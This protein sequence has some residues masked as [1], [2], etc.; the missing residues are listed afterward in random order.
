MKTDF[1]EFV[2]EILHK[3][4][5]A[6]YQIYIVGGVVRDLMLKRGTGDWD[7]TTDATPEQILELFPDGF[8]NNQ[9][10]T[11]GIAHESSEKPYEITTYRTEHGYADKRRPDKVSW[12]KS[13]EEDLARRDFT[14]NAMAIS[15]SKEIV[16]P[17]GGQK[18]LEKK[19][20][21]TVGNPV[22]RFSEDSLRMMRAVRIAAEL[23]FLI[24]EKTFDAIKMHAQDLKHVSWERIRDELFKILASGYPDEGTKMLHSSGLLTYILPELE[25]AIGV[26]QKS[27]GRHHIYDVYNHLLMALKYCPSP[28]PLVRLATLLHDVGKIKTRKVTEKGVVT[29]YNHEV[30]G[31]GQSKDVANRLKLSKKQK[32]K[33]WILIRHHQFTVDERQTDSAIRRFIKNVGVENLED[34]LAL[35]TGDRLGGGAR[36]TSWR[37]DK[38]KKRLEEVQIQPFSVKDLAINGKDVMETLGIP[39]GPQ[40]GEILNTLFAEVE[41]DLARNTCEYLL[42]RVKELS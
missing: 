28:D 8:Y 32:D 27:P 2:A 1:P 10:G 26:E 15:A 34:M 20:I 13:L 4:E 35:R 37:L 3:F 41:E 19:I 38:F 18:D 17:Y 5:R 31:A 16:D 14:I 23:G 29:F 21:R 6:G 25:E 7:F 12:G 40:V 36:E 42:E 22:D 39:S 33:L 30:V 24:E 9:F 11:V